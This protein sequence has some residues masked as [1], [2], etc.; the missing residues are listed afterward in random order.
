MM[1][2]HEEALELLTLVVNPWHVIRLP[3]LGNGPRAIVLHKISRQQIEVVAAN[4]AD[5]AIEIDRAC[6]A[7][8]Q[9]HDA[10]AA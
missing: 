6:K 3:N 7:L 1:P 5:L 8:G 4:G 9:F 10:F 2:N